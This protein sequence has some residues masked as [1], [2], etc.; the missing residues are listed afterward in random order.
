[1]SVRLRIQQ[2]KRRRVPSGP[3]T[4]THPFLISTIVLNWNR[5]FLLQRTL[6][7]YADTVSGPAEIFVVDNGSVDE[8]REVIEEARSYLPRLVTVLLDENV[9]GEAV[10]RCLDKVS[11]ELI[12]IS[13]NDQ[14][15][16]RTGPT[17]SGKRFSSSRTS[18][19]SRFLAQPTLMFICGGQQRQAA[20]GLRGAKSFMKHSETSPHRVWSARHELG[21]M[22]SVF[23]ILRRR[24]AGASSFPMTD[25]FLVISKKFNF[26]ARGPID[27]TSRTSAMS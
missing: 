20:F 19:S 26:G 27:T 3:V 15:T 21:I 12:H 6:R 5:A 23:T 14:L 10:N 25:D 4:D 11:G 7:S 13:E 1:M 8:S 9:G 17:T 2:S 22:T 18:V 24:S 16:F